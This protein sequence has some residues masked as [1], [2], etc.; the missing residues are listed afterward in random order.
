MSNERLIIPSQFAGHYI[1]QEI[2][3]NKKITNLILDGKIDQNFPKLKIS[4]SLLK[5]DLKKNNLILNDSKTLH[6]YKVDGNYE[7]Y[8]TL[9]FQDFNLNEILESSKNKKNSQIVFDKI[10]TLFFSPNIE[11]LEKSRK[12]IRISKINILSSINAIMKKTNG[13][14][15]KENSRPL[16]MLPST[17]LGSLHLSDSYYLNKF[18][19]LCNK[20]MPEKIEI[21]SKYAKMIN[22]I[23]VEKDDFNIAFE[24][25]DW[26]KK[27]AGYFKNEN[28]IAIGKIINSDSLYIS[29]DE[30]S[31]ISYAIQLMKIKKE[32][33]NKKQITEIKDFVSP[34][35]GDDKD[36]ISSLWV[37][38]NGGNIYKNSK[39]DTYAYYFETIDGRS[40][41]W[42][43]SNQGGFD[44]LFD[45]YKNDIL[46]AFSSSRRT[47][48]WLDIKGSIKERKIYNGKEQT[49]LT[50]VKSN[51]NLIHTKYDGDSI[52]HFDEKYKLNEFN[53]VS[54][55]EHNVKYSSEPYFK[56][57]VEDIDK[58]VSHFIIK[59]K[60]KDVE[61]GN[62]I[63]MPTQENHGEIVG[64]NLEN[65]FKI[66]SFT[67][68][69]KP[70]LLTKLQAKKFNNQ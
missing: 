51:D 16:S 47:N 70:S 49:I 19:I 43:A 56:Y 53:I 8:I 18:L 46:K 14:I 50:R 54:I 67:E 20:K 36:K 6:K 1:Y 65:I 48:I 3:I 27:N 33:E 26:Y 64:F 66:N 30:I 45:K 41:I 61:V 24:A 15:E 62:Y 44:C 22:K 5:E 58:I 57:I 29:Q 23:S 28:E 7:D 52:I 10:M 40:V 68:G 12:L 31:T 63:K 60:I 39:S 59:E 9:T 38:L 21:I 35:V 13:Y 2:L 37:K 42:N 17:S 25:I 55:S 11:E 4:H 34:Y 69:F 32:I